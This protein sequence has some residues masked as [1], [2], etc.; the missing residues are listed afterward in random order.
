[1][2]GLTY[3]DYLAIERDTAVRHE[4]LRGEVWAMS[5]GTP[6]HSKIKINLATALNAALGDGP[7]QAY[8]S[9]LKVRTL[10]TGLATYADATV[11]CGDLETD[12]EDAN[13]ITNP[14]AV[15]EVLSPSTERWDRG[16]KFEHLGQCPS[17]K[18]YVLVAQERPHVEVYTRTAPD[19]WELRRFSEG[20][21]LPLA[22]IGIELPVDV[23][24]RNMPP[25]PDSEP[26]PH[27]TQ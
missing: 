7:C 24:Y 10:A 2:T 4:F 23:L 18:L 15:F 25:P 19:R 16:G 6:R 13:A 12:P 1:M 26:A 9:D 27:S 8:D 3:A 14:T 17:L 5:G 22:P 21:T 11:V 20:Q